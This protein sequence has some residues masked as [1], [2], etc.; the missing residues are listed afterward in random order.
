MGM[1][2]LCGKDAGYLY[3]LCSVCKEKR[4]APQRT[5]RK[6]R[7]ASRIHTHYDNLKV[8][9]SAP[10]EVIRAAYK[11]LSQKYH[12]DRNPGDQRCVETMKLINSAYAVLS[13][14]VKR[15]EHDEWILREV[16]RD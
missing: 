11:A 14:S 7:E 10:P 1:C 3:S 9:R 2:N 15:K 12:P 5:V 16:S 8:V 6:G 4:D 13:D